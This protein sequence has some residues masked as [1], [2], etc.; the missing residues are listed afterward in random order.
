MSLIVVFLGFFFLYNR[1]IGHLFI[2]FFSNDSGNIMFAEQ[3]AFLSLVLVSV[4]YKTSPIVVIAL[5]FS[6]VCFLETK[7]KRYLL[8]SVLFILNLFFS[9]TRANIVSGLLI[10]VL[11]F[12]F[13][14]FY[15]KKKIVFSGIIILCVSFLAFCLIF[16]LL[17]QTGEASYDTKKLHYISYLELFGTDYLRTIVLGFGPGSEF[18]SRGFEA[19]TASTELSYMELI[20]NYGLLNAI[21]IVSF[22]VYPLIVLFFSRKY[23]KFE[24]Y[25]LLVSFLSYLFIAGTNPFLNSMTGYMVLSIFYL[26]IQ[27]NIF[28]DRKNI[29]INNEQ[30]NTVTY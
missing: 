6:S 8:G 4:F 5:A 29:V 15:F 11:V 18:F 20:R 3:K 22:Y 23:S 30:Y 12:F 21:I 24:K 2:S 10:T 1:T 13:Y 26:V 16:I 14:Q 28:H 19:M 7:K 27:K 9:G 25:S 17:S